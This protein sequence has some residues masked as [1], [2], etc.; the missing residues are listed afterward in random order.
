[1]HGHEGH[2]RELR[3]GIDE[4]CHG[5][6]LHG[7]VAAQE[8][9]RAHEHALYVTARRSAFRVPGATGNFEQ[10]DQSDD[11][12]RLEQQ[13][14]LPAERQCQRRHQRRGEDARQRHTDLTRGEHHVDDTGRRARD[15]KMRADRRGQPI[16]NAERKG[17]KR[18]SKRG[19]LRADDDKRERADEHK[20][21]RTHRAIPGDDARRQQRR[22]DADAIHD[23][24][25]IADERA[26]DADVARHDRRE[27]GY[28]IRS[29]GGERLHRH[30]DKQRP[31]WEGCRHWGRLG[32]AI[33]HQ[34]LIPSSGLRRR[35]PTSLTPRNKRRRRCT[36]SR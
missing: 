23:R 1:M 32:R 22:H 2:E 7:A 27:R 20:L 6:P 8:A 35:R 36:M 34:R 18:D 14:M 25:E 29:H 15:E 9:E 17:P 26:V 24:D 19:A 13:R 28:R 11:R 3:A 33:G 4:A 30:R 10:Q 21:A 12:D 5:Q 31:E 16:G